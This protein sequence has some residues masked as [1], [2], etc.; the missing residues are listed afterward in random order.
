MLSS[1]GYSVIDEQKLLSYDDYTVVTGAPRDKATGSVMFGKKS[2]SKI[3]LV[4]I[5]TGEQ[6]GSHFGNSL[7][8]TDLNNDEC[9]S[10]RIA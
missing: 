6:V 1:T 8:A 2:Q 9:V 4:Q 7:A 10:P 5:I 3:D